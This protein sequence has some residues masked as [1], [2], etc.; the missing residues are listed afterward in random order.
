MHGVALFQEEFGEVGAIL[1]CYPCPILLRMCVGLHEGRRL[2]AWTG[3]AGWIRG[4]AFRRQFLAQFLDFFLDGFVFG[5]FAGLG[6][7]R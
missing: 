1:A 4:L 6:G 2:R 7:V 3:Q 5:L